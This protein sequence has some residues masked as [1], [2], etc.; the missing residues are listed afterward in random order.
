[1]EKKF[2]EDNINLIEE[3]TYHSWQKIYSKFEDFDESGLNQEKTADAEIAEEQNVEESVSERNDIAS[4]PSE[5]KEKGTEYTYI[6]AY[7][8]E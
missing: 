5:D 1:M 7:T 4:V 2:I 3:N 6:H 8:R